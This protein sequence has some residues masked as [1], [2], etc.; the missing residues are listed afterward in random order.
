M[1]SSSL[2]AVIVSCIASMTTLSWAQVPGPN[3]AITDVPGIKVGHSTNSNF[4]G[5]TVVLSATDTGLG[6]AGSVTQR[7]GS[8]GTRETDLLKPENMVERINAIALSGGS[9][10][11]LASA[12]GVMKCL[13]DQGIGFGVGGGVV[14]IVPTAVHFDG[15][16]CGGSATQRPGFDTGLAACLAAATGPVAQGNVGAGAGAVSGGL[17]GGLGSAS[18]VLDNGIIVGALVVVNSAGAAFDGNGDLYAA[19][20]ALGDEFEDLL[21]GKGA[22]GGKLE[23]PIATPGVMQHATNAVVATNVAITKAQAIKIAEMADDG[24]VRAL[25]PTHTPHDGD[26]LFAL[27]TGRITIASLGDQNA[28]LHQIGAAAADVVSRAVVHAIASADSTPCHQSYCDKYSK[29][30]AKKKKSK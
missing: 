26:T 23:F 18:V 25:K 20:L 8:P 29:A 30:C 2:C 27:G 6:V 3:N 28:V 9:A 10:Y 7:G 24:L 1:R 15:G 17:K 5:A 21:S 4:T 13:E 11:G 16:R 12:S 14:P 22:K 19:H